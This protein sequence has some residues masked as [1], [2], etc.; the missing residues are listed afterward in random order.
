MASNTNT[1]LTSLDFGTIKQNFINY[2]QSQSQF[3]DYNFS[4]SGLSVLLDVL[5]YN[6]QYNAFY[7]NM[8]AN[9][10]FMDT[11]LQRSSVVS[12]AKLLGYTPKSAVAPTAYVNIVTNTSSSSVTLP[13]FTNFMSESVNGANYNF[14]SIN[15]VTVAANN[16]QAV[17]NSVELKQGIPVNYSFN[18]DSTTNPT[19]T[20]QLPDNDI[21]TSTLLVQVQQSSSNSSYTTYT[22]STN[23]LTLDGTSTVYFLQ[24]SLNGNYEISFGDGV[25]GKKLADGNI[26]NVFYLITQGT[27]GAGAN[28]FVL[29]DSVSGF[30]TTVIYGS[31]AATTGGEKESISSIKYTAPK[32]YAAQNRAVTNDDYITLIQQN[33]A[34]FSFDAVNVWGGQEN[35]PPV[36]GQVFVCLK[37]TGTY[38]LTEVQKQSIIKNVIQPISMMTVSPNIVDPDYNYI[39]VNSNVLYDPKKTNYTASQISQ[40]VSASIQ[41]FATRTLNTFNSTFTAADLISSI[42]NADASIVTNDTKIRIQK[43]FYP[44]FNTPTTYSFSFNT[45][46]QRGILLSG[47]GS[48]PAIQIQD[49]QDATQTLDGVYVEETPSSTAGVSSIQLLNPGYSYTQT[50]TVTI[51]GD[52]T[53]A[54]AEATLVAGVITGIT[55]TNPGV[56]YTQATVVITNATGDNLGYGGSAVAVLEGQYG[57]LRTYYYNSNNVKTILN[58]NAG[59]IDYNNG[60]VTLKNFTPV[61]V[62]SALGELTIS[63][64]PASTIINSS[65][66]KIL[67]I[68]PFDSNAILVN[69]TAK[70]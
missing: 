36:Y 65:L 41:Q 27:S 49:P 46:L 31:V 38:K 47:V 22:G 13:A 64:V 17:F 26:V 45:P 8:V 40:I 14:V 21:D 53:G 7:L 57:T 28:N 55:V 11:A 54:T 4:G 29:T 9:E 51:L 5:A 18:V 12:H 34:G 39:Q 23:Y 32:A 42:Q 3:S 61:N 30:G 43:K 25:L 16:G 44:I 48:S 24:E 20:F 50:P 62:D 1:Q 70:T 35:D 19:Y 60:I 56:G 15:P 69:V 33:N 58:T 52:G 68:D 67:T 59:T 63:A 37:P 10:M 2:L 66:N 6:T